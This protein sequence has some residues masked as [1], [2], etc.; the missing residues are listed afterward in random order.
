MTSKSLTGSKYPTFYA[1][2]LL[3]SLQPARITTRTY[4]GS[5]PAPV[6][7]LRQHNG[8]LQ[9]GAQK[10]RE[11]R[12]WE[13]VM[14]VHGFPSR[15][16]A[17]Q[18][19]WAWQHPN[20]TRH[21][22]GDDGRAM[23]STAY[24]LRGRVHIVRVMLASHPYSNWPLGVKFFSLEAFKAWDDAG[25]RSAPLPEG[26]YTSVELEGV[27]G[28]KEVTGSR[29]SRN[30]P[31]DINDSHFTAR[32]LSMADALRRSSAT[33]NCAICK[34]VIH[35]T[36]DDPMT[37]AICS[38]PTCQSVSHIT[39]LATQFL[40]NEPSD[41]M[42]PRGG[43]CS[44]CGQWTLWG[45]VVRGAYRRRDGGVVNTES[46]QSS[47]NDSDLDEEGG[48]TLEELAPKSSKPRHA[49]PS[50]QFPSAATRTQ[51]SSSKAKLPETL[52][53]VHSAGSPRGRPPKRGRGDGRGNRF[54]STY[55]SSLRNRNVT[56]EEECEDFG[57]KITSITDEEDNLV[58][59]LTN[60][61]IARK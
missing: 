27:D 56:G 52:S 17:L 2:Y 45:D 12:P 32:Q 20:K 40:S 18:F 22:K 4:I 53:D 39:C 41:L 37:I 54:H 1:C 16:S 60:M 29:S 51:A 11:G 6:R 46:D 33:H 14:L 36:R 3:K 47:D 7:R 58:E 10:T 21:L 9:A 48:D 25:K 23:V 15:L 30:G 34:D 57:G 61:A 44:E 49:S 19:E 43:R 28:T 38:A 26:F 50:K 55:T 31:I 35:T 59:I 8:E 5:T 42:I 24:T 13:M